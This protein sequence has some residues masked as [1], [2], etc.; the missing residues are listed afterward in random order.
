[1]HANKTV[2]TGN[3]NSVERVASA[4][5]GSTLLLRGVRSRS[6]GGVATALLGSE[7][8]F[9]GVTGSCPV[10]KAL[11]VRTTRFPWADAGAPPRAHQVE[12]SITIGRPSGE[13]YRLWNEPGTM[14][15]VMKDLGQVMP[16]G[17]GR[18]RWSVHGPLGRR[19]EWETRS[20]AGR[21]G[22]SVGWKS[23]PGAKLPNEGSIAFRPAPGGRG[24]EATLRLRFDPPGGALGDVVAKMLGIVPDLLA[25]KALRRFKSLAETG[26][27]PTTDLNPSARAKARAHAH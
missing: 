10:Y 18:T 24:T 9:R 1:M 26:E 4:L 16:L 6:F 25:M 23:V 22:E 21:D 19:L 20:M 3:V 17:E 2:T 14:A 12:R 27:V 11:G 15:L 5:L 7:L 8:L 13:L